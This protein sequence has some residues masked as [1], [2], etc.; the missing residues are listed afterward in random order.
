MSA[1]ASASASQRR[2]T[3][4]PPTVQVGLVG[5]LPALAAACSVLTGHRLA[6]MGAGPGTALGG[7]GWSL[8]SWAVMMAG[9]M[10]PATA[11]MAVARA[12]VRPY[13]RGRE[14]LPFAAGY[15]LA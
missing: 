5:A 3:P 10:P 12:R 4:L 1:S 14:T 11:P 8:V 6:G 7:L 9:M 15:L 2:A 13:G